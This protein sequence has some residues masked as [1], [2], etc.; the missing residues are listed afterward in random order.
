MENPMFKNLSRMDVCRRMSA[1]CKK[2][3]DETPAGDRRDGMQ[4][5]SDKFQDE[6]DQLAIDDLLKALTWPLMLH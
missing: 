1:L 4:R 5:A 6:A 3:A 2:S